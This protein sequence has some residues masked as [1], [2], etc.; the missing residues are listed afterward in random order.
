MGEADEQTGGHSYRA[1][2]YWKNYMASWLGEELIEKWDKHVN[3]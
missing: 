1:E 3:I 2:H